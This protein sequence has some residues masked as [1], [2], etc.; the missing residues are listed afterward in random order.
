MLVTISK[1]KVPAQNAAALAERFR[2]C[3]HKVDQHDGFLGLEV[4]RTIGRNPC[5]ILITRWSS[6]RALQRYL[7]S[8]DLRSVH[9]PAGLGKADFSVCE[10][11]GT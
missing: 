9:K 2:N 1:F 8:E 5:F 11:L 6:R 4:L 3:S 7:R 10:V